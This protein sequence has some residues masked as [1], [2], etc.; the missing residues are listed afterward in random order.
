MMRTSKV[1]ST[2]LRPAGLAALLVGALVLMAP[3]HAQ[4]SGSVRNLAAEHRAKTAQRYQFNTWESGVRRAGIPNALD[5]QGWTQFEFD[6]QEGHVTRTYHRKG[7]GARDIRCIVEPHVG[8]TSVDSHS[9]LLTWLASLQSPELKDSTA[10]LGSVIGDVGF[11][12]LSGAGPRALAWIAFTRGNVAVRVLAYDARKEPGLDLAG[13]ARQIDSQVLL[14]QPLAETA[15][16][17]IPRI[18]ELGIAKAQVQAGDRVRIDLKVR[19]AQGARPHLL[20]RIG[21]PGRG[22]IERAQDGELYFYS[23]APGPV[24]LRLY[25]TGSTGTWTQGAH[26]LVVLDD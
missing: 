20:W 26:S 23:T 17:P 3:S 11:Y 7:A 13:I 21:G 25:V 12:S 5:L 2:S 8:E 1:L 18:E 6:A 19:D 4:S 10:E 24:T 22:Y 16:L 15:R 9:Q 14:Q